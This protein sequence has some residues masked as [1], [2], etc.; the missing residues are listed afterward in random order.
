MILITLETDATGRLQATTCSGHADFSDDEHGGD[1]VCAAVS[2]LTG[3]LGITLCEVL[4]WPAAVEAASGYFALRRPGEGSAEDHRA[5]D[6]LLE[7]WVRSVRGLEEN[8][9][10]WV[11]VE[12]TLL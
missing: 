4:G 2:A 6:V 3:F 1:I 7:G 12:E 11:K 5:L 8:Y 10:G 9:S